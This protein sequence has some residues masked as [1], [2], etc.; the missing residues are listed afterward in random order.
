MTSM[1]DGSE[2]ADES[3][4]IF[5]AQDS[6]DMSIKKSM[7][8]NSIV[9]EISKTESKKKIASPSKKS[10]SVA[11]GVKKGR[12]ASNLFSSPTAK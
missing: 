5:D 12:V 11:S 2:I 9:G 6:R 10:T 3:P 4:S 7:K 1:N 8:T